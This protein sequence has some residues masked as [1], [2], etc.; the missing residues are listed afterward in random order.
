MNIKVVDVISLSSRWEI[1][2]TFL[3]GNSSFW[4]HYVESNVCL[5]CLRTV[6]EN[7]WLDGIYMEESTYYLCL[8]KVIDQWK[9]KNS[10]DY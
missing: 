9:S 10:G 7:N 4:V 1:G 5:N 8:C 2:G 6:C 3:R